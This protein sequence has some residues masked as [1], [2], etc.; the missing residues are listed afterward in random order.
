MLNGARPREGCPCTTARQTLRQFGDVAPVATPSEVSGYCC[1]DLAHRGAM[2][3]VL[4]SFRWVLS[5]RP[6]RC[7]CCLSRTRAA[8]RQNAYCFGREENVAWKK[9][10][11]PAPRLCSGPDPFDSA[12]GHPE[13]ACGVADPELVEREPVEPVERM[14]LSNGRADGRFQIHSLAL[15]ATTQALFPMR[16][17]QGSAPFRRA[18][19]CLGKRP[20]DKPLD[21]FDRLTAGTLGP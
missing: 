12:Q 7:A 10:R 21:G 14:S 4:S 3:L 6:C 17:M 16:R 8:R 15:V 20:A 2:V 9:L 11:A 19:G 1:A 13:P 5:R 18:S